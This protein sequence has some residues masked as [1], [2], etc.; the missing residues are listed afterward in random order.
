[1]ILLEVSFVDLHFVLHIH[2]KE[3]KSKRKFLLRNN[4]QER[5][6]EQQEKQ[7]SRKY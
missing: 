3:L 5:I 2:L 6:T 1:M 7:K 4:S